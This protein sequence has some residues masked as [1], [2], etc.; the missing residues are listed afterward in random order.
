MLLPLLLSMSIITSC[1]QNHA[2]VAEEK[3]LPD[4]IFRDVA[5]GKDTAQRMDIY[6]PSNRSVDSTKIIVLIHGGGWTAGNKS[7]FVHYIDSFKKRLP[8]YAIFNMNYRLYNGNNHFPA[9]E[10]D[11]KAAIDFITGHANEYHVN[12]TKMVLL[13]ASAG[14]HLALLQAYKYNSP[15]IKAVI[16]FFGPTDLTAMFE[17]PWHPLVNYALNMVTGTTPMANA[18]LYLQSSPINFVS[19]S[20]PPTLILHGSKDQMVDVS[21]SKALKNKLEQA[22]VINELVIYPGQ[23]HGWYG[24]TLSNSFDRIEAFLKKNVL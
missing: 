1:Q 14:G 2:V 17:H 6:L 24:T 22:G 20:T 12:T 23:Q 5:Y 8:D 9:Q 4:Q 7:E 16:D 13:G 10:N 18:E 11:V 15:K 3:N 21:Q 19:S